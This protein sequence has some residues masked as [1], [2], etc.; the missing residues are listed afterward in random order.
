MYDQINS[1]DIFVKQKNIFQMLILVKNKSLSLSYN[2]DERKVININ[3][4][5]TK[6]TNVT[7]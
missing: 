6:V 1:F 3:I 5:L 2:L 4:T 7:V